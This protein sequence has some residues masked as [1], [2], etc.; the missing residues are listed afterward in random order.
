MLNLEINGELV[1]GEVR[2]FTFS[3]IERG[4]NSRHYNIREFTQRRLRRLRKRRLKS[5]FALPQTLSRVF[6]L[7]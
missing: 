2:K 1:S 4:F 3:A 5:E 7:A 6:H